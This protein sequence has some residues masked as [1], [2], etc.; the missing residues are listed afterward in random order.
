MEQGWEMK[1]AGCAR[2]DVCVK[3]GLCVH[4]HTGHSI[5][6][7]VH[8]GPTEKVIVQ[9]KVGEEGAKQGLGENIPDGGNS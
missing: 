8:L 7:V 3:R 4:V 2:G 6:Q 5:K 1:S 9:Q